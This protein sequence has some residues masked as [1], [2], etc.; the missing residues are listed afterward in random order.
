MLEAVRFKFLAE[1][2][3]A[4]DHNLLIPRAIWMR[5]AVNMAHPAGVEPATNGFGSLSGTQMQLWSNR[6]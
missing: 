1:I 5:C 2:E 4:H 3:C 6:C